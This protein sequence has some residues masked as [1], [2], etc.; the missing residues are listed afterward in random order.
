[1]ATATDSTQTTTTEPTTHRASLTLRIDGTPYSVRP[2]ARADLG[3]EV[4]RGFRLSRPDPKLGRVQHLIQE[5]ILG[6]ACS[7]QDQQ[8]RRS[9][10][11]DQC[12]HIAAAVAC[13][14]F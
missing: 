10:A 14:L 4:V 12:K 8:Y 6:M 1:M 2:I 13:G 7:C 3:P 9:P 5:S 11:G